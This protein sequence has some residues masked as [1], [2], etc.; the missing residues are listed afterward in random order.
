MPK[1]VCDLMTRD[2][3]AL[4]PGMT[5]TELDRAL[6]ERGVSGGPVVEDGVVVGVVSRADVVRALYDEQV[7][8]GRVSG[9]YTSP[10]PI[11]I[12]A[13]EQLSNDSRKIADRIAHTRV[14]Q[15]MT[16]D[17]KSVGPNDEVE[18]AARMMAAEGY[19]RVPVIENG[20]VVGILTSLDVVR[21]VGEIGLAGG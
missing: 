3:L 15:V 18:A 16:R 10:F 7:E 19:H 6:L 9:F 5:L 13:L 21:V 4:D 17:V 2:V 11:P 12:P 20:V 14:R 1:R 8:A